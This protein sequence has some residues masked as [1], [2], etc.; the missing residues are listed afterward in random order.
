[1]TKEHRLRRYLARR[2]RQLLRM[3]LFCAIALALGAGA[4]E[5]YRGAS[6]IGLPDI[7]DPF[8]VSA[9]TAFSVDPDQDAYVLLREAREKLTQMPFLRRNTGASLSWSKATPELRDW[10]AANRLPLELFRKAAE[11][12]DAIPNPTFDRNSPHNNV[13]LGG[14]A[15]LALIEASRLEEQGDSSGA[16]KWYRAVFR[17]KIHTMRRASIFQRYVVNQNCRDL[18]TQLE[19]WA[20]DRRTSPELLRRA[21]EEVKA[22]EPKP[23]WDAFSLKVSYL[24]MM[25]ELDRKWGLVQQGD[26][27]DQH[28]RIAGEELPPNIVG[29]I[30]TARRYVRSEPERS[31]RVLRLVYAN[32]LAHAVE[33]DPRFRKPAVRA[34]FGRSNQK[35]TLLFYPVALDGPAAARRLTPENLAEAV[36]GTLD[37]RLLLDHW[38]W[39]GVRTAERREHRKLVVLLASELHKR[40][41]SAPPASDEALVGPYLDHLPADGTDELDDG[42]ARSIGVPTTTPAGSTG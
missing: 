19:N 28:V 22:G 8:D 20:A 13:Y 11:L 29:T 27:P 38:L 5:I 15:W 24:E 3:L 6:M 30:Y 9:F 31:R 23:E 25:T 4:L 2:G 10:A 1:M 32:W 42:T 17:M 34:V 35:S 37:A 18:A 41:H 7:G 40:E 16:W 14:F 36:L 21:L 39:P 33:T 26:D 12:P